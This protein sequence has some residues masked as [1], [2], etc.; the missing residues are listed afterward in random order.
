M[1]KLKAIGI[2][3]ALA[4][5]GLTLLPTAPASGSGSFLITSMVT[6]LK[7]F[8]APGDFR[9]AC[10]Y[11]ANI[12]VPAS[13]FLDEL[14][15]GEP[16]PPSKLEPFLRVAVSR[17]GPV[18]A[19]ERTCGGCLEKVKNF[20]DLLASNGTVRSI[21]DM[22]DDACVARFRKDE[23]LARQCAG[24]LR[25]VVAPLIDLLLANTPPR[26]A[27]ST[28]KHRPMNLCAE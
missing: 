28:G 24:E 16:I 5:T 9:P 10:R 14:V 4:L 22:M 27:C 11:F 21:V 13:P 25:S 3:G 8:C 6:R 19:P 18:V 23:A 12:I 17:M 7:R 26:T 15:A 20:E 1:K 2:L